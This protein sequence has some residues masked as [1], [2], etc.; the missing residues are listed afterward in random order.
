M[1]PEDFIIHRCVC[2]RIYISI[3]TSQY[4]EILVF[5]FSIAS[6]NVLHWCTFQNVIRSLYAPPHSDQFHVALFDPQRLVFMRSLAKVVSLVRTNIAKAE[7]PLPC[8]VS[9]RHGHSCPLRSAHSVIFSSSSRSENAYRPR[10]W[11]L[12]TRD[13]RL[14]FQRWRQRHVALQGPRWIVPHAV[15]WRVSPLRQTNQRAG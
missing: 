9:R 5:I 2:I 11:V 7:A 14:H 6:A 1:R 8:R 13:Q 12:I 15:P 4:L 3:L 10:W